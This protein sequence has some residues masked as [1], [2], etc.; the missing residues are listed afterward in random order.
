MTQQQSVLL[1]MGA[2]VSAA[3]SVG[4]LVW[5]LIAGR[6]AATAGPVPEEAAPAPAVKD[7]GGSLRSLSLDVEMANDLNGRILLFAEMVGAVITVPA[8]R[9]ELVERY[10]HA[11]YPGRMSDNQVVGL[12]VLVALPVMLILAVVAILTVPPLLIAA[13]VLGFGIGYA[14]MSAWII[15]QAG[16]RRNEISRTMPFVMDLIVMSMNAGASFQ[17]AMEQ[18]VSDY[19]GRPIGDEF[20]GVLG[21]V[22]SGSPLADAMETFRARMAEVPVAE[23]FADDVIQSQ[24]LG[25]PLAQTLAQS[26]ERFKKLRIQIAGEL[27]GKAKVKILIPGMLILLASLL[28]LF[29]PFVVKFLTQDENAGFGF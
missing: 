22:R 20:G 14:G 27:A 23:A 4:S 28:I 24:R 6:K 29:G 2:G 9:D 13:P 15:T 3:V 17:M 7:W 19:N 11:G 26:S 21:A 16:N 8:I 5:W 12:T 1:M 25:R 18:V 10:A